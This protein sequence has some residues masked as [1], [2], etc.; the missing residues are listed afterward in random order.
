VADRRRIVTISDTGTVTTVLD[1]E[2]LTNYFSERDSFNVVPGAPKPIQAE[3]ARRFGGWRKVGET[4]DNGAITWTSFVKGTTADLAIVN[5]E[6]L[7]ALLRDPRS[8]LYFEW[9]P[10]AASASTFYEIRGPATMTPAYRWVTFQSNKFWKMTVEI[11]VAPLARGLPSTITLGT[12]TLPTV[13]ALGTAIPGSA[14]ALADVQLR[15][16]A[17]S[18]SVPVWA[19][20]AWWK[21]PGATIISTVPPVGIIEA[22]NGTGFVGFADTGVD[23][24]YRGSHGLTVTAAGAGT[25]AVFYT[26]DPSVVDV[27]DFA[28]SDVDIEVWARIKLAS[29]LV[30]PKLTIS[31]HP[32]V[33]PTFGAEQFSAEW[34]SAGKL[35]TLPSSGSQFRLT[36]L[37]TLSM[38]VDKVAPLAYYL[39]LAASWAAGSSGALAVDYLVLVPARSRALSP[40]SKPL[41]ATFPKFIVSNADT[42]KIVRGTDLSGRVASGAGAFARDSGLGGS[43]IELPP[44]NVDMLLW[45]SSVVPDDPTVDTQ[46]QQLSHALI[47]TSQLTITPRFYLAKGQ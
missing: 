20:F 23:A 40:S 22:E 38:P 21:R 46:T 15:T 6:A 33:G 17:G 19:M 16:G 5:A 13:V 10:E 27:D 11:P 30:S 31:I 25:A 41:D 44:G 39:K 29:T 26:I 4:H 18:G 36:R 45:L 8:D 35:L 37:G 12:P 14:P 34:G 9:R 24:T 42:M 43:L 32:F 28:L 3:R 7:F 47:A 1:V 2:D